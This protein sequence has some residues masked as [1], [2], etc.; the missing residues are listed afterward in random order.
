MLKYGLIPMKLYI[1][2]TLI[3]INIPSMN[4]RGND[5]DLLLI[6]QCCHTVFCKRMGFTSS[7]DNK[8]MLNFNVMAPFTR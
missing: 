8:G 2:C 3:M 5:N 6:I 1:T 7:I 4:S